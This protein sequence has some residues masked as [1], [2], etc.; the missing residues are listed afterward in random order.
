MPMALREAE[1]IWEGPLA[2]GTGTLSGASGALEQLPVTWA[3]RRRWIIPLGNAGF[4]PIP[5][6]PSP[7]F[8]RERSLVRNQ[9][10]R[11]R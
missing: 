6:S 7:R 4:A 1:V 10:M 5:D 9:P 2:S 11:R 3:G 8:T